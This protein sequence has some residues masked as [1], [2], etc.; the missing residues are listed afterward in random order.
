[1]DIVSR[2][3]PG[4]DILDSKD[5]GRS[6]F[7]LNISERQMTVDEFKIQLLGDRK[8][9]FSLPDRLISISPKYRQTKMFHNDVHQNKL[10]FSRTYITT[11][12][13]ET[14]TLT[15]DEDN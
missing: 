2:D 11:G 4:I 12:E 5:Q 15:S 8:G 14:R 9:H 3:V 1:M 10:N 13:H 7:H 6:I